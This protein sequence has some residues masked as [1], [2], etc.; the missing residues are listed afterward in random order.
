MKIPL[1]T[2][3]IDQK[4]SIQQYIREYKALPGMLRLFF[5][6][7]YLRFKHLSF[8]SSIQNKTYLQTG[9]EFNN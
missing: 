8:S 6:N 1:I 2:D 7:P 5:S 4:N 9:H 3:S